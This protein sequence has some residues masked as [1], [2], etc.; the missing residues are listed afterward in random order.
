MWLGMLA[1]TA[2]Q[3]G[4][5]VADP[6]SA[7]AGLPVAYVMWVAHAAA[8]L[9]GAQA[10]IPAVVVTAACI[11]AAIAI[12]S[13][14]A[15]PFV[16]AGAVAA[17]AVLVAVPR[18]QA[19]AAA[20]PPGLRITFLDVGQG[21]ATLIQRR[22]AAI[23]VDTGPPDGP[24]LK[25]LRH[26]G[27]RRLDMLVVTHAQADHDGGAAAVL[28]TVPVALV[29]DGRD[30]V[31]D[32]S[33]ARMAAEALRRRVRVV[34]PHVGDVLR[35]GGIVLRVLW[36]DATVAPAAA[37]ED[38]NQRAIVAEVEADGTRTLLTADAESDVLA[39]LDL[40]RVDVLK[41]SHHG[42]ADA[43]LPA[44]LERL[45]PRVAAIEVGRHNVYG[46]PAA[47]TVGALRAAGAAVVRTDVDGSVRVEPIGRTLRI[48]THA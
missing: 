45:R 39:G 28:H 37:R 15:R 3:L 38:P 23:L 10:A 17:V 40:A 25:R 26:A 22:Q 16:L 5:A 2:G 14:R 20:A 42:S 8:S 11:A 18:M 33:G 6:L 34:R 43:G 48:T 21:D 46:H 30:G 29:L 13:R 41:V 24:I 27:V 35:V 7:L 36:P 12:A 4:T 19:D 44:L 32:G 47:A 9:P 1:A 31:R